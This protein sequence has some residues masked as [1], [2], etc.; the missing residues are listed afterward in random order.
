MFYY[1]KKI[2]INFNFVNL[3]FKL[4]YGPNKALSLSTLLWVSI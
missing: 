1:L 3:T 2:K 4:T